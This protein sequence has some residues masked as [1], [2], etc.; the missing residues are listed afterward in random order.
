MKTLSVLSLAF[1]IALGLFAGVAALGTTRGTVSATLGS[2]DIV[3]VAQAAAPEVSEPRIGESQAR[4]ASKADLAKLRPNVKNLQV[5][6]AN[7]AENVT[8]ALTKSGLT[9]EQSEPVDVWLVELEA[10]GQ[11]GWDH[12]LGLAVI[13][14][15]TGEVIASGIGSYN[16]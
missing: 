2:F 1:V 13:N 3:Q 16:D 6:A 14:A 7:F 8:K 15:T 10:P 9:F 4:E 11:D 5:K 12:V